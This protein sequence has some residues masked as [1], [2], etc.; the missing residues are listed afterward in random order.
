[1]AV[2]QGVHLP[3]CHLTKAFWQMNGWVDFWGVV[4]IDPAFVLIFCSLRQSVTV[5]LRQ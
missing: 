3:H 1:M 4:G 2:M 5:F